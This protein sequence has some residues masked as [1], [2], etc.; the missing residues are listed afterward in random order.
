MKWCLALELVTAFL[1]AR[2]TGEERHCRRL[3]KALAVER[4][5]LRTDDGNCHP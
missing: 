5:F 4:E 2:F 3:D 1:N